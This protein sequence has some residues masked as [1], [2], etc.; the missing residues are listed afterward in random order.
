M[1]NKARFKEHFD[2]FDKEIVVEIIDI[3][4]DEYDERIQKMTMSILDKNLEALKKAA[5]AFKGVIANFELDCQAYE[6]VSAIEHGVSGFLDETKAGHTLSYEA[7]NSF[8]NLIKE[9]FEAFKHASSELL[10]D[11]KAIRCEYL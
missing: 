3:F 4:V 5:H 1:I 11:L 6:K 9:D 2:Y 10:S 7:S 8:Y